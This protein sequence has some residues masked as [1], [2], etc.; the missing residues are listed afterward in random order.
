M[1]R[2]TKGKREN[3]GVSEDDIHIGQNFSGTILGQRIRI[4]DSL[5]IHMVLVTP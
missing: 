5:E 3:I 1:I 4:S 2:R